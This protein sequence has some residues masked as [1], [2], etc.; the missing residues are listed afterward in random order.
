MRLVLPADPSAV[1]KA[2]RL[3]TELLEE[4][5]VPAGQRSDA[6][7][8]ANE[9][10]A[11]AVQHGSRENDAIEIVCTIE[12]D[13]LRVTVFDAA[14]SGRTPAV[15]TPDEERAQGRGLR[16]V[17]QLADSWNEQIVG[18]RREVGFSLRLRGEAAT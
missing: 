2:R 5:G 10:M 15:L 16:L 9:L 14:R 1:R 8:L 6:L 4:A 3:L 18:G 11:N 17:D 13:V 12:R 7:L